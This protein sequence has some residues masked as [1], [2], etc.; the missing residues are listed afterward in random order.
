MAEVGRVGILAL[1]AVLHSQI[2]DGRGSC[3]DPVAGVA[4]VPVCD[5]LTGDTSSE[6]D[7]DET[8]RASRRAGKLPGS[9]GMST[10]APLNSRPLDWSGIS[11]F[12][13]RADDVDTPSSDASSLGLPSS[14]AP[15]LGQRTDAPATRQPAD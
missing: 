2:K 8:G 6:E 4:L 15:S 13:I 1:L 12:E 10:V 11:G 3:A 14:D 9:A 5:A 7:C